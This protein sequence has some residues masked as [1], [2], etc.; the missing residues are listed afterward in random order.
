MEFPKILLSALI[1]GLATQLFKF[2]REAT[3]GHIKWDLL[4]SYGGMP[5]AHTAFVA[6]LT[7]AVGVSE[8]I[9]S[10]A[11]A[12]SFILSII[13][14]RDAIGFRRYLGTHGR[15]IN[16]LMRELPE[17]ED[18]KYPLR[19]RERVGH[20]P[21]EALVGTLVGVSISLICLLVFF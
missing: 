18:L 13:I 12:I 17:G 3:R 21:L 14:V 16:M 6:A 20:T 19:L 15:V 11:F 1:A 8:G 2:I 4:N 10:A 5:S 9:D 7:T